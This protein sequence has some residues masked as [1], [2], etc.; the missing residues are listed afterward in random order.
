MNINHYY[1]AT[2]EELRSRD[3]R[4]VF[5]P[6][7]LLLLIALSFIL[8]GL[9]RSH[10]FFSGRS[11]VTFAEVE[12]ENAAFAAAGNG[13]AVVS[14]SRAALYSAK[15]QLI[16]ED[17]IHFSQPM[18]S[19]CSSFMIYADSGTRE[20]RLIHSNGTRNS[21][22]TEGGITWLHVNP[23]G[24]ITVIT[25][26]QGYKGCVTV[27]DRDLTPLFRWDAASGFPVFARTSADDILMVNC[28]SYGGSSVHFF[29]IDQAP[30]L[31]CFSAENT[32]ILCSDFLADGT[33]A[34]LGD[35]ALY[36]LDSSGAL[37]VE[38]TLDSYPVAWSLDGKNAVVATADS[39]VSVFSSAGDILTSRAM[40]SIVSAI[41]QKEDRL[42][43][44]FPTEVTLCPDTLEDGVSY[45]SANIR[46]I[47]LRSPEIALLCGETAVERV[48]F[49]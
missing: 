14:D 25:D 28:V 42:L 26:K 24:L 3:M 8:M 37:L 22:T 48:D 31:G 21:I 6:G 17:D 10:T 35:R 23:E 30:E 27:Y 16:G 4:R 13:L 18:C 47:F 11:I 32:M 39:C 7:A 19:G 29:R 2:V 49:K 20:L 5:V 36:L 33:A 34:V 15:G 40:S 1:R 12:G 45:Q 44:L 9:H 41:V 38:R 43:L 46:Q